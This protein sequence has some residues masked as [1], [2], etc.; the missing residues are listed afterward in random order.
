MTNAFY[1]N[2]QFSDFLIKNKASKVI[3]SLHSASQR[4]FS[5]IRPER[6]PQDFDIIKEN[7]QYLSENRKNLPRLYIS[8]VI[9]TFNFKEAVSLIKLAESLKADKILFKPLILSPSLP[10]ELRLG[11]KDL[12]SLFLR[13]KKE[14]IKVPH[15]L[16]SFFRTVRSQF[17]RSKNMPQPKTI[18]KPCPIPWISS[19]ISLS[20][21]VL[22]CAYAEKK[23]LG[24]I[25]KESFSDIWNS[26]NYQEFRLG[27]YCGQKCLGKAVYPLSF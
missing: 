24:N 8:N 26:K 17:L 16:R 11:P 7:L 4:S 12:K 6:N 25:Y 10:Q 15:N 20:G 19:V 21:D 22:G 5:R 14:K 1:L 13:V 18:N 23:V 27:K 3:V 9:S 2:Q